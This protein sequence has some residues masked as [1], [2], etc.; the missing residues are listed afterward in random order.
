MPDL[1][2]WG[3]VNYRT[4]MC[5]LEIRRHIFIWAQR[6]RSFSPACTS[7]LHLQTDA[8]VLIQAPGGEEDRLTAQ[9]QNPPVARC[10]N[11]AAGV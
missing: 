8:V 5:R 9:V 3:C 7:G 1:G 4:L 11:R 2:A 10:V 6:D